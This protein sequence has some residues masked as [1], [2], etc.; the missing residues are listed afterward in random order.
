MRQ[1]HLLARRMQW[2][3]AEDDARHLV[4]VV[5]SALACYPRALHARVR[6]SGTHVH[7]WQRH[8]VALVEFVAPVLATHHASAAS[9]SKIPEQARAKEG[10]L[11]VVPYGHKRDCV[12]SAVREAAKN[13][14]CDVHC[15]E[16][17]PCPV[18]RVMSG[19]AP[20]SVRPGSSASRVRP[21]ETHLSLC[22]GRP[23]RQQSEL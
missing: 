4:G 2:V 13:Q 7:D 5:V 11:L 12:L 23:A 19:V 21:L 14:R 20:L 16:H 6:S 15:N 3:G 9:A 22:Q 17:S 18:R 1:A 8:C 10:I